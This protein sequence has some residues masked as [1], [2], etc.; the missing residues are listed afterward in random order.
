M[1]QVFARRGG[2][3]V[4]EGGCASNLEAAVLAKRLQGAGLET[5]LV[6]DTMRSLEIER[7]DS[8]INRQVAKKYA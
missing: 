5:H 8:A 7:R 4:D 2:R 1:P 6:M 3:W